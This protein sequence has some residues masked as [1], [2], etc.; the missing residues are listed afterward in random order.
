MPTLLDNHIP[1][2]L[3]HQRNDYV[4]LLIYTST[5]VGNHE[6][7]RSENECIRHHCH[8]S[9]KFRVMKHLDYRV[10]FLIPVLFHNQRGF[11]SHFLIEEIVRNKNGDIRVLLNNR[12]PYRAFFETLLKQKI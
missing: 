6:C 10:T 4:L 7:I 12:E 8:L 2:S 3:L 5:Y 1:M 9:S 11:D